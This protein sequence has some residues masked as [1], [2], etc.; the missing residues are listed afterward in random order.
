MVTGMS[1]AYHAAEAAIVQDRNNPKRLVPE[2][3]CAGWSILDIGCGMGQTLL[4]PEFDS[5]HER[6][7]IDVDEEAIEAGKIGGLHLKCAPAEDTGFPDRR[8]DLVYSRVSL[9]YTY[10]QRSLPE[11]HRVLKPGGY[12]WMSLHPWTLE[13]GHLKRAILSGRIKHIVD[14]LYVL[15]NGLQF[16][17]TGRTFARPWGSSVESVQFAAA[18]RRAMLRNGFEDIEVKRSPNH[19]LLTARKP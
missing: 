19:F 18:M 7:G 9:P 14:R 11:I 4:A 6:Y 5:A 1:I 10:L 17:M 13:L 16:V 8:F 12:V 2:Y 15:A 3:D